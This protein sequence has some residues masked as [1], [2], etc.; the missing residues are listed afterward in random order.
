MRR[1]RTWVAAWWI[2]AC[3][4]LCAGGCKRAGDPLGEADGGQLERRTD[5]WQHST[6]PVSLT[7]NHGVAMRQGQLMAWGDDDVSRQIMDL[8]GVKL[9]ST[10]EYQPLEVLQASGGLTDL[11]WVFD[12]ADMLRLSGSGDCQALDELAA[13]YCPDFWESLEPMEKLN[14]AYTDG[15]VYTLRKGYRSDAAYDDPRIPVAPPYLMSLRQDVLERAG[16]TVPDSVEELEA[17]LYRIKGRSQELGIRIPLRLADV[18]ESPVPAWMG[19]WQT[20]Y[21]D[22]TAGRVRT[23]WRQQEWTDYLSMM[24]RWVQD[25]IVALPEKPLPWRAEQMDQIADPEDPEKTT[26]RIASYEYYDATGG[27]WFATAESELLYRDSSNIYTLREGAEQHDTPLPYRLVERPLAYQGEV[28]YRA[29]DLSI[30]ESVTGW[31]NGGLFISK[32]CAQPDR[33]ILFFQF[34]KSQQGAKLTHWGVEGKHYT[35]QEDGTLLYEAQYRNPEDYV[36]DQASLSVPIQ[37]KTGI[38]LWNYLDDGWVSGMMDASPQLYHSNSD[39]IALR[40]MKIRAGVEHKQYAAKNR[41]PALHFALPDANTPALQEQYDAM[42]EAWHRAA[43]EMVEAPS[44]EAMLLRWNQL[45]D[46]L[47]VQG[48]DELEAQMTER[49]LEVLPRYQQAGYRTDLQAP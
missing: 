20:I 22:E 4:C 26:Y 47:S 43:R 42:E 19:I 2:A 1:K 37:E 36:S 12:E 24:R 11:V 31:K 8:T 40:E 27:E 28:R 25:G 33:A 46:E 18:S 32:A 30:G 7:I 34:L 23:P 44:E 29:S 13:T 15:H 21:W 49:Y 45:M 41:N 10:A 6:S 3:L 48:I 16:E 17:L 35:V 14:N 38:E 39:L 5:S 9:V